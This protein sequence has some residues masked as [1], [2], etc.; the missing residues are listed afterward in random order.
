[1]KSEAHLN[2][3]PGVILAL[4]IAILALSGTAHSA[5]TT[6]PA[7]QRTES[8]R[9]YRPGN[10]GI[11]GDSCG[12]IWIG[13]DNDPWIGG[14]DPG[15]EEG[16]FSKFVA[17]EDRWINVS[18]IDYPVIGHPDL[19]GTTRVT[20]IVADDQ[21]LMWLSTWRGLLTY[22][23]AIGPASLVNYATELP[24]LQDGFIRDLDFAPDGTLW[25]ALLG[26]G[27]HVGGLL[28][29]TPGSGG[30]HYWTGGVDPQ[31]GNDWPLNIWSVRA[32]SVQPKSTGGYLV[33]CDSENGTTVAV[34]DSDT[35]VFTSYEFEY[36]IG[37]I[38]EMP[39]KDC[40][41]DSG[42]TWMR[43]FAGFAGSDPTFTLDYRTP[44]GTWVTQDEPP[45][46]DV[47]PQIWAFRAFGDRQALLVDG[48]NV[49][50]RFNGS[51][52]QSL[53]QWQPDAYTYDITIDTIG[54][55]WVCGVGGAAKRDA[56]TGQWQRYRVTNTSQYDLFNNDLDVDPLTGDVIACANAG[57]G[58]G[59]LTRF[60]GTRWIG[61]NAHQYG[62]GIG[63]PF[64]TDNSEA[65]VFR[66][67]QGT[68]AVNPMYDAI[69]EWRGSEWLDHGGMT[70]SEGLVEDSLGQLWSLGEYNGL[71]YFD[72][73]GW[74]AVENSGAGGM[75][76]QRDP[77]RIGTVWVSTVAQVI[78]TDGNYRFSRDY[79]DFPE[80][81]TQ[82]DLFT[83]VA[84]A[85]GGTAWL[86]ST[87]GLFHI[88]SAD[89]SYTYHTSLGGV[90][91]MNASPL[92]V[93]PDGR[94]WFNLF[95]PQGTGLHGLA[96]WNGVESGFYPAP[97]DG[98]PQWG[99]LPHAQ[100]YAMKVRELS[101]GYEL[102]MS[103]A[104]RGIA[105][106]SITDEPASPT[107]TPTQAISATPTPR[108]PTAT[109]T[110][111]PPIGMDLI[112]D[113][114]DLVPG[115]RLHLRMMLHNPGAVQ[116]GMDAYVL[117]EVYGQFWFWPGWTLSLD[118]SNIPCPAM[119]SH[120][121]DVLDFIWPQGVGAA[122]GLKFWGAAFVPETYDLI[123]EV[124]MITWGYGT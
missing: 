111:I 75:N 58:Y 41:D 15:S 38:A 26:Y 112:L 85:P 116:V 123:G 94:I 19:T 91:C 108:T 35:Q 72:D 27:G 79:T 70:V 93:S 56:V 34:Y 32:V 25:C 10:T 48:D 8:W 63:W 22:D 98:G 64:P 11:Q 82:S 43:R 96:W 118:F 50:W 124:R 81:D 1:M 121:S 68:F 18:N 78:R 97:R 103:C 65:V 62:L 44:D 42:N 105:V 61:I 84:A 36:V 102:W 55:V 13:P 66:P 88:D 33:W 67:S 30:W 29:Y 92:I 73:T 52:W 2:R 100:I 6:D 7:A 80:L 74:H 60:D 31:G 83:T 119:A 109:P 89:G 40:S 122:F 17:A 113:D 3:F 101:N 90:S 5:I 104:S 59:G 24:L 21:G 110:P 95:D 39:G 9:Y 57:P 4:N 53:G 120:E 77:E 46:P 23:P 106:L 49:T 12:A 117:L 16:G 28:R 86:G 76:I 37:S 20:D 115:D 99:G 107:P 71:A 114:P 87:Q 51:S 69:H 14:C 45:L 47:S 54:N